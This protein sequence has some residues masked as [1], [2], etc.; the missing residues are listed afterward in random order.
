MLA[1][2]VVSKRLIS[3]GGVQNVLSGAALC[4]LCTVAL[5]EQ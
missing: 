4:S 1:A 5:G 2:F 3:G